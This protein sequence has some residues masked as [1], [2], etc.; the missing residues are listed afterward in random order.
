MEL[1]LCVCGDCI[2]TVHIEA[3]KGENGKHRRTPNIALPF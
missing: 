1:L 2:G 3:A